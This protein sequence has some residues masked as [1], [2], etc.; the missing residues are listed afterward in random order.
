MPYNPENLST[1]ALQKIFIVLKDINLHSE[2]RNRE[3]FLLI[4]INQPS[5]ITEIDYRAIIDE[6]I[7]GKI[8]TESLFSIFIFLNIFLIHIGD[9]F[10]D[11]Y[12]KVELELSKR[13]KLNVKVAPT[14][15]DDKFYFDEKNSILHFQD[16]KIKIAKQDKQT[17]AHK[18]LKY[19][20][21]K[22]SKIQ[23][24]FFYSEIDEKEFGDFA[25]KL[26]YKENSNSWR[27]Y[28]DACEKIQEK[29]RVR[30]GIN[31]FLIFNS[32]KSGRVMINTK[33]L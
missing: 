17:N 1:E 9:T 29:I 20:F 8:V 13:S 26:E 22:K 7:F 6:L 19:I 18:I 14:F 11:F 23:D 27:R 10:F 5:D 3:R 12:D 16:Q 4:R 33:Y 31:D 21:A 15:T 24:E 28:Y 32:G 25:S 2:L 30:T